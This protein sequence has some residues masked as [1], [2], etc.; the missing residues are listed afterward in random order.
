MTR[1]RNIEPNHGKSIHRNKPTSYIIDNKMC[2][3]NEVYNVYMY[4]IQHIMYLEVHTLTVCVCYY[5]IKSKEV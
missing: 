3:H 4:L 1:T 5:T 2:V